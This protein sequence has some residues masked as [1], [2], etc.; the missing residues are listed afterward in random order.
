MRVY[1]VF[2]RNVYKASLFN[3]VTFPKDEPET[4][5]PWRLYKEEVP[6]EIYS[7]F[8][9][10]IPEADKLTFNEKAGRKDYLHFIDYVKKHG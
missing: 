9:Y 2:F 10:C 6:S 7:I 3:P 1:F 5:L 4:R 8:F